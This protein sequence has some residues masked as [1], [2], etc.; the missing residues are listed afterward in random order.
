MNKINILTDNLEIIYKFAHRYKRYEYLY[1]SFEDYI[2]DLK[3]KAYSIIHKWNDKYNLST[4]LFKCLHNHI[5]IT[6]Y[7]YYQSKKKICYIEDIQ[8]KYANKEFAVTSDYYFEQFEYD[9]TNEIKIKKILNKYPC[10]RD[11]LIKGLH[12][13]DVMKKYNITQRMLTYYVKKLRQE[14]N[15]IYNGELYNIHRG[16]KC[17][18]KKKETA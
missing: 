11:F 18:T 6:E 17:R 7:R 10:C 8:Q 9:N 12:Y 4:F 2:S 16:I 3:L 15:E 1:D 14:I 5:K 13:K